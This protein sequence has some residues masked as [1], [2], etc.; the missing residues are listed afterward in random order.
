MVDLEAA[1]ISTVLWTCGYRP[2]YSWI[3]APVT[4]EL[5]LPVQDRGVTEIPGLFFIGSLW[6]YDL[7]SATLVGLR[8]DA[9]MLAERMGLGPH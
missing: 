3:D 7:A 6:Q 4:D 5:G 9:G 8:R 2:D 1:G